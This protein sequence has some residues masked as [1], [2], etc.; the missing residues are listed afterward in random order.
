VESHP[1]WA[2]VNDPSRLLVACLCAQWCE[3]CRA[4]VGTFA[5]LGT[6]CNDRLDLRWID[7][8]DE[9][10]LLDDIDVENFPTLLLCRGDEVVFL[11]A[12]TP[13]PSTAHA[14]IDR[15]LAGDLAPLAD[16]KAQALGARL[17]APRRAEGA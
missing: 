16:P 3:S 12:V 2:Y 7:I 6:R 1:E 11:G 5:S 8:E 4:Y 17:S 10:E 15:A 14:L 13:H 9:A